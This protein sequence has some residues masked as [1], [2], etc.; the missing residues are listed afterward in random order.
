MTTST[1]GWADYESSGGA[2]RAHIAA[3]A[4][5]FRL[6][7]V[8]ANRGEWMPYAVVGSGNY[9]RA[10]YYV[11]AGGQ[12]DANNRNQVPNMRLRLQT[13]FAQNSML[14]VYNHLSSDPEATALSQDLR[15][16]RDPMNPSVYRVDFDPVDVPHLVNNSATE[17][18]QR[19]FEAFSTDPQDNGFVAL[20]ESVLGVYPASL[21]ATSAPPVKVYAT[22]ASDAGDLKLVS[23]SDRSHYN[24]VP[25]VGEGAFGTAVFTGTIPA[26]TESTAGVTID[27]RPVAAGTIGVAVV[28]INPDRGTDNHAARV[29][30]EEGKQYRVRFH[31]T[32]TQ[33]SNRQ[34]QIRLRARSVK[35]NWSQK[36]E[37]GGAWAAGAE[38]NTIAQQLLPGVGCLNPDKDAGEAGGWYTLVMHSPLDAEIRP[39]FPDGTPLATRMPNLTAQPGP[40][41]GSPSRRDLLVGFDVI[42]TLTF[43]GNHHLE[44]GLVTLDRVEIHADDRV[45]D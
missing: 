15:P 16:S 32:S 6:S 41:V 36:I 14:E 35:F 30:V 10:K 7:G 18:I 40:G 12:A 38:N 5:H 20:T 11:Y 42:D 44:Q 34:P 33:Q 8:I 45:P 39:D 21:L 29:R 27:S 43:M 4:G 3:R 19:A 22:T 23:A 25:G 24:Y 13:R 17:G 26:S 2:Y 9:A 1:L 28:N 37:M 31:L